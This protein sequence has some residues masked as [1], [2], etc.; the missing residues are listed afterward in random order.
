[1]TIVIHGAA[2]ATVDANDTVIYDG[3]VAIDGDRILRV[4]K[5]REVLDRYPQA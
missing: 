1:M 4:G 2:V 3:A 5:S